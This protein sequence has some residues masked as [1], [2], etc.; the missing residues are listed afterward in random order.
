MA[1]VNDLEDYK[2]TFDEILANTADFATVQQHEHIRS[3]EMCGRIPL[4]L[5][6]GLLC[7]EALSKHQVAALDD[8]VGAKCRISGLSTTI[9]RIDSA[10]TLASI[11]CPTLVFCG[12][13]D[14]TTPLHLHEAMADGIGGAELVVVEDNGHLSALEKTDAIST[15]LRRWLGVGV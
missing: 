7:D 6:P 14:I 2:T 13:Q 15:A 9:D 10:P 5:L 3:S 11:S 4:V 8:T 1:P 12:R